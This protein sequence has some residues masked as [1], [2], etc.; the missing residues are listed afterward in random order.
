MGADLARCEGIADHEDRASVLLLVLGVWYYS[1]T[2]MITI[3]IMII[4]AIIIIIIVI[5]MFDCAG[6]V[7]GRVATMSYAI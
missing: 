5:A 4:V 7:A 3:V 2:A 6:A 1:K